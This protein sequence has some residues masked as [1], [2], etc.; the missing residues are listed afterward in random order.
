MPE[1]TTTQVIQREAPE[2]EAYKI[3]LM[4]QAKALTGM[5]PTGG[6]PPID[7]AA[8]DP[9]QTQA[10]TLAGTGL[11]SY[12]PYITSGQQAITS[13]IG[14]LEAAQT[15]ALQTLQ[16]IPAQAQA[17][18]QAYDPTSVTSYM[19]PYQQLV[20]QASLEQLQNQ[21]NARAIEAGAFGGTRANLTAGDA[22]A[23]QILEDY[24]RNFGQAQTASMNA[25][26]NQQARKLQAADI[27]TRAGLGLGSLGEQ[28]GRTLGQ[29]GVQQAGLG[30]LGSN[31][32]QKDIDLLNRL[33]IQGRQETQQQL[34]ADRANQIQQLYEPYQRLSFYS[35]ILRGAPS[36]QQA[37]TVATSPSPSLLN[38]VL[39][40][41][42]GGLG[43]YGAASKAG[44]V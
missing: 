32:S 34:A 6:L 22:A 27:S 14:A 33:G 43:I 8:L 24:S 19:D 38:Q 5:E 42:I 17:G 28:A 11:G 35:D 2:I 26:Q 15:P 9:L 18:A 40:G 10:A 37:L 1:T 12:Q 39:G 16:G 20:T 23:R 21:M 7:V 29:L 30:E 41:G 13:G 31:L 44:I 4:E 25:Y 36:T 3:G